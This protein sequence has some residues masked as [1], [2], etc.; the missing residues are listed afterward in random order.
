MVHGLTRRI[1][2]AVS[3]TAVVLTLSTSAVFAGEIKGSSGH[4]RLN[5]S[6]RCAG[7]R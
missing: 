7:A 5:Q 1:G 6:H 4:D 3:I 2:L